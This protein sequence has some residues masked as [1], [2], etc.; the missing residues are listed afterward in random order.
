MSSSFQTVASFLYPWAWMLQP[1]GKFQPSYLIC[2]SRGGPFRRQARP[3]SKLFFIAYKAA[4]HQG[5]SIVKASRLFED[6]EA[7]TDEAQ[8]DAVDFVC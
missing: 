8:V 7:G 1:G 3:L 5:D 6:M 4:R 2:S